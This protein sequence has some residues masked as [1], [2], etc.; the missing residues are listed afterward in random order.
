MATQFPAPGVLNSVQWNLYSNTTIASSSATTVTITGI[1]DSRWIGATPVVSSGTGQFANSTTIVSVPNSSTFTINNIPTIALAGASITISM[2]Q[3]QVFAPSTRIAKLKRAESVKSFKQDAIVYDVTQLQKR[4]EVVKSFKQD[5]TVYR[6]AKLKRAESVKGFAQSAR[7]FDVTQLQKRFEVVKSF[8][9]D[10]NV[11]KTNKILAYPK[12]KLF[13]PQ[14]FTLPTKVTQLQKRFEVVKGFAQSARV[15]DVTQL[16]KRFEVVKSFKQDA[17]VYKTALINKLKLPKVNSQVFTLATKVTQLQKRFEVVKSFKQ[18]AIVYRIAKLKIVTVLRSMKQDATVYDITQLQKRFEVV[19]SFKQ[20]ATVYRTAKLKIGT[21]LRSIKQEATVFDPTLINKLK[22]PKLNSQIFALATKVTQLQKRFEVVKSFKQDATVFKA[23]QLQK[24]FE[25]VKSFK[26]DATVYK[27]ALINKLKLPK[28]NAQ[29][30]SLSTRIAKLRRSTVLKSFRQD[31]TAYRIAKLKS[32]FVIRSFRQDASVYKA[33]LLT[34]FADTT[35]K[36]PAN[37]NL[38]A[39][40]SANPKY[41]NYQT[42]TSVALSGSNSILTFTNPSSSIPYIINNSTYYASFDGSSKYLTVPANNAF[43]FGLGDYTIE[44][45]FNITALSSGAIL[46]GCFGTGVSSNISWALTQGTGTINTLRL[47]TG[48]GT[49]AYGYQTTTT[50]TLG[51]WNHYAA[52]RISGVIVMVDIFS[53][54]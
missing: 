29:V 20:D 31:A 41:I 23:T 10:A 1:T 44:G 54:Y 48:N 4:F 37:P 52:V 35:W 30:F 49:Q 28:V 45:W 34:T 11:Y 8:K 18:D 50:F 24:R 38:I 42:P 2:G 12:S 39:V 40:G 5:A 16:Q 33:T 13:P 6:T 21:V 25:V 9:Q 3:T 43:I 22:L 53:L 15:F 26:Q 14:V 46:F 32:S 17:T 7:V 51:T 19:K 27:T 47:V 36:Y